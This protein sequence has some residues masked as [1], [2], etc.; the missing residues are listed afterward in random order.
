MT[1]PPQLIHAD[2]RAALKQLASNSIDSI[3]TDPPYGIRFMGQGW[4]GRDI[5]EMM[6]RKTRKDTCR[7]DGW[8]RHDGAAFAAGTYDLSPTANQA[9][10]AWC[11]SWASEC[12]R[13]L[14]PGG[15]LL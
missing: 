11:Q 6:R 13:V 3:V 1:T 12:L 9:F 4:D 2:C 5:E 14:K 10:E 7:P 8:K 15:H